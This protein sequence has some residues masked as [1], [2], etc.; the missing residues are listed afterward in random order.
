MPKFSVCFRMFISALDLEIYN[1]ENFTRF[2][3]KTDFGPNTYIFEYE[4]Q[5]EARELIFGW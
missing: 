3:K 2:S 1:F 5:L 4:N